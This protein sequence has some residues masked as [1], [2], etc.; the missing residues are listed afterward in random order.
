MR[1]LA[2]MVLASWVFLCLV[3]FWR[4]PG[5]DAALIAMIGGWGLL[6]VAD[7]PASVFGEPIGRGGSMH[8]VAIP[9]TLLVNKATAIALGCLAG[10]MLFDWSTVGRFRPAWVD[11]PILAWCLVPIASALA[12]GL[13]PVSGLAQTRY[14]V[15]AWGVPYLVGR[16]YLTDGESLRR[17]A[18]GLVLAGMVYVPFCLV[19]FG[20]RPFLYGWVYGPHPYQLVGAE[21]FLGSRPVVF[22][23][24]GNQLGMWMATSAVSATWLWRARRL[25]EILGVPAWAVSTLLAA[26][27]LLSQSHTAIALMIAGVAPL[28]IPP[29]RRFVG[30]GPG[31]TRVVAIVLGVVVLAATV[32]LARKAFDPEARHAVRAVFSTMGKGSFTWRLARYEE[33][34]PQIAVRPIL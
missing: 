6:P 30:M 13:G 32:V 25:P 17:L 27:C 11:L 21:R 1:D 22:L 29:N 2:P 23:E 33:H 12:N 8:A 16:V 5:R 26:I 28:L 3:L 24:D 14:L 19:E 18:F 31:M 20:H 4:L 7:F 9:T 34:F 15:L 10:S